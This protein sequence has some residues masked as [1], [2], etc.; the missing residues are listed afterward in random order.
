MRVFLSV[1]KLRHLLSGARPDVNEGGGQERERQP[2]RDRALGGG[3]EGI[4]LCGVMCSY[5]VKP[6]IKIVA[7]SVS[8]ACLMALWRCLLPVAMPGRRPELQEQG[9]L[10]AA[11]RRLH[12]QAPRR[13]AHP[14]ARRC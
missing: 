6:A 3:G 7:D 11:T 4:A 10:P 1:V 13:R 8:V 9:R 2:E 14:R 5:T 12:E